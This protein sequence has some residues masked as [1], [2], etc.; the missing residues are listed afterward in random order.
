MIFTEPQLSQAW[1]VQEILEAT[2]NLLFSKLFMFPS[3]FIFIADRK[4]FS[5]Y[6]H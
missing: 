4:G 3:Y 6:M 2:H 1:N 5:W